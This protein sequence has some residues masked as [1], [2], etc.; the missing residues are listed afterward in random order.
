MSA[1]SPRIGTREAHD[2]QFRNLSV[3]LNVVR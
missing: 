1:V 2:I 3:A